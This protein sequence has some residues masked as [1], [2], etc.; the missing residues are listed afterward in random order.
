VPVWLEAT[1]AFYTSA[2]EVYGKCADHRMHRTLPWPQEW[3]LLVIELRTS[4]RARY[5]EGIEINAL[6]LRS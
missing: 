1:Q 3:I 5:A 2:A 6:L 4:K